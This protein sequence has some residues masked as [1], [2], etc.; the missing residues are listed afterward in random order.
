[1]IYTHN[2][3]IQYNTVIH[4]KIAQPD[5]ILLHIDYLFLFLL[6]YSIIC[7]IPTCTTATNVTKVMQ[8]Y[9][10]YL[11]YGT[12]LVHAHRIIIISEQPCK[13]LAHVLMLLC[14]FH[15][16]FLMKVIQKKISYGT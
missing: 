12:S 11:N 10:A 14:T 16:F 2:T 3:Y 9:A 6:F 4:L 15:L 13:E 5:C 7:V 1:M 8:N